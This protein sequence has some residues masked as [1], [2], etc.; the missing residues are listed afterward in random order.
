MRYDRFVWAALI[1]PALAASNSI[2]LY[3]PDANGAQ[4]KDCRATITVGD[5][6]NGKMLTIKTSGSLSLNTGNGQSHT[7][8][9]KRASWNTVSTCLNAG[10]SFRLTIK[11]KQIFSGTMADFLHLYNAEPTPTPTPTLT[12]TASAGRLSID[13]LLLA[14]LWLLAAFFCR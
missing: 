12:P 5:C 9:S 13:M 8:T 6:M 14:C 11:G 2:T 7:Q 1:A 3:C 10:Q 4:D